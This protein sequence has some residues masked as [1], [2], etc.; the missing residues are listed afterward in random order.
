MKLPGCRVEGAAY[1]VRS[2]CRSVRIERSV[3]SRLAG[4]L[5][6]LSRLS[7]TPGLFT[8]ASGGPLYGGAFGRQVRSPAV[9]AARLDGLTFHGCGTVS[10]DCGGGRLQRSGGV[11]VGRSATTSRSL[12]TRGGG[13]F[14]EVRM[15]LWTGSTSS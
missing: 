4:H 15:P 5:D 10:G 1:L 14:P 11:G 7:R 6:Q 3:M 12:L 13:L 8:P 2:D 9:V